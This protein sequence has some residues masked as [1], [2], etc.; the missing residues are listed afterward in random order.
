MTNINNSL[1]ALFSIY[2]WYAYDSEVGSFVI[3][4]EYESLCSIS[5]VIYMFMI[6]DLSYGG[7]LLYLRVCP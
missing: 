2:R 4:L 5:Y 7:G 1:M 6:V 3:R